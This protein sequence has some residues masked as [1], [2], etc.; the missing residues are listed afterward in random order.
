MRRGGRCGWWSV[1]CEE[2]QQEAC[3]IK[4]G[5]SRQ[6]RS[7]SPGFSGCRSRRFWGEDPQAA[8]AKAR[9]ITL[10]GDLASWR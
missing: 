6:L 1:S 10:A 7:L 4:H 2:T 8:R 5:D 9:G 3:Q